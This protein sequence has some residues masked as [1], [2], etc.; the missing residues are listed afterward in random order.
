MSHKKI[1][2]LIVVPTLSCSGYESEGDGFRIS[3]QTMNQLNLLINFA[4]FKC[5]DEVMRAM[6]QANPEAADERRGRSIT[7]RN[8][9][10]VSPTICGPVNGFSDIVRL[11]FSIF[12]V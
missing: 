1:I 8:Y 6:K 3:I 4:F 11:N 7:R 12:I 5:R 9:R 2:Y 10:S